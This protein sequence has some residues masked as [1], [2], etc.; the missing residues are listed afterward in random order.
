M[1]HASRWALISTLASLCVSIA[2][3]ARGQDEPEREPPGVLEVLTPTESIIWKL[4]VE[5]VNRDCILYYTGSDCATPFTRIPLL[6]TRSVI[7]TTGQP[8][9]V[10][11]PARFTGLNERIDAIPTHGAYYLDSARVYFPLLQDSAQAQWGHERMTSKLSMMPVYSTI[12]QLEANYI[13][14]TDPIIEFDE[15]IG[16]QYGVW[17]TSAHATEAFILTMDIPVR[18]HSLRFDERHAMRIP[19]PTEWPEEALHALEPQLLVPDAPIF[20]ELVARWVGD[21]SRSTPA[22]AAKRLMGALVN[23]FRPSGLLVDWNTP[24][25]GSIRGLRPISADVAAEEMIGTSLDMSAVLVGL[26]RAAGIPARVVLGYDI[27]ASPDGLEIPSRDNFEDCQLVDPDDSP[28]NPVVRGW[29]EFYL[30]DEQTN[31][32]AWI[33]VDPLLQHRNSSRVP[34]VEQ[35][36]KFFGNAPCGAIRIPLAHHVASPYDDVGTVWPPSFLSW[37]ANPVSIGSTQYTILSAME[38]PR[39]AGEPAWPE[40]TP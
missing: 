18:T 27:G 24:L 33:P 25:P 13:A 17:E 4:H 12:G 11:S 23:E 31:Q 37:D 26:Y 2:S 8:V 5:V 32:G 36:W 38:M 29:V 30:Y 35:S 1:Q 14:D 39:R 16:Y 10:V 15:R 3:P 21:P 40:D 34:P 22:M 7:N 20:E 6:G 28:Q 19:W 9:H